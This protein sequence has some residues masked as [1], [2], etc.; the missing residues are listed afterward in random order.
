MNLPLDWDQSA[1]T[2]ELFSGNLEK[3]VSFLED[4]LREI[5]IPSRRI[6]R[7]DS[8]FCVMVSRKMNHVR[9]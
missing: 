8:T 2:V 1:A 5:G 4:A 3:Q 6:V 7:D 9:S